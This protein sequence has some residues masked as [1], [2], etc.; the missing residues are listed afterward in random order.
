MSAF[1]IDL[2]KIKNSRPVTDEKELIKLQLATAFLKATAIM[3]S[4]EILEATGIHKSD[5]S[6]IRSMNL[7]RFT[8]DRLIGLLDDLGYSTTVAIKPKKRAS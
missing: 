7:D 4:L 3:E 6:R 1:E 8:I 2:K 5:L